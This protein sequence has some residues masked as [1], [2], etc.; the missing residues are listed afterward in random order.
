M[1]NRA[2]SK[3]RELYS[4]LK[5]RVL[6]L[7]NVDI[8][9][10]K[11]Y[12]AFKGDKNIIDIEVQKEQLKVYLNMKKKE[13][14]YESDYTRFELTERLNYKHAIKVLKKFKIIQ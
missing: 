6:E 10:K 4:G 2:S 12:I 14:K 11:Q 1:L 9:P 5:E 3:A 13:A 7:D 8:E